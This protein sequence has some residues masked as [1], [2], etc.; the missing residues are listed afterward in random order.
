MGWQSE[1]ELFNYNS[2]NIES[3]AP[4]CGMKDEGCAVVLS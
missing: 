3:A 2:A 1:R 4:L